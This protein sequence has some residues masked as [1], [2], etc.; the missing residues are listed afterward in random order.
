MNQSGALVP[1]SRGELVPVE[2]GKLGGV[3]RAT[4]GGDPLQLV[5]ERLTLHDRDEVRN[6]LPDI[7]GRALARMWIDKNFADFFSRNPKGALQA[8][9]VFLPDSMSI[10]FVQAAQDRPKLIV[11]EQRPNS[12]FKMRVFYLQLVMMAGR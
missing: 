10:E 2:K 5:P 3:H 12:K 11:Y 4:Q 6:Y 8:G 9:G 1:S 7:L